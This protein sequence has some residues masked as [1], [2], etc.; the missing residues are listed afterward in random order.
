M[1]H[2]ESTTI[3]VLGTTAPFAFSLVS[4]SSLV[5]RSTPRRARGCRSH[6]ECLLITLAMRRDFSPVTCRSCVQELHSA[7]G[8]SSSD[9]TSVILRSA[10]GRATVGI[11]IAS[12]CLRVM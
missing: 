11:Q 2:T 6:A 10:V 8:L 1:L 7:L 12:L 4:D 9:I 5:G 3:D